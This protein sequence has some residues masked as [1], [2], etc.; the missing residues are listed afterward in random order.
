MRILSC[1]IWLSG[2]E[3]SALLTEL[4]FFGVRTDRTDGWCC[5]RQESE[6]GQQQAHFFREPGRFGHNCHQRHH[7]HHVLLPKTHFL[8]NFVHVNCM[9]I[10]KLA[11]LAPPGASKGRV[12]ATWFMIRGL[13]AISLQTPRREAKTLEV[14]SVH[15]SNDLRSTIL[16]MCLWADSFWP[17]L[18]GIAHDL[19]DGS[20]QRLSLPRT[21]GSRSRWCETSEMSA[22]ALPIFDGMQRIFLGEDCFKT[23]QFSTFRCVKC[24]LSFDFAMKKAAK[25]RLEAKGT[26][27]F[28]LGG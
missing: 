12:P 5:H 21:P 1:W 9:R 13:T 2:R 20:A 24:H 11:P 7:H 15:F 28:G 18:L 25:N 6:D 3:K 19:A 10:T 17:F 14:G 4:L 27:K 26:S 22:L 16:V 8:V 23:G